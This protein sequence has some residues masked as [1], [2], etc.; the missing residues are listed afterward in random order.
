MGRCWDFRKLIRASGSGEVADL[1]LLL[2]NR[3]RVEITSSIKIYY[4]WVSGSREAKQR[5]AK[6]TWISDA[7]KIKY[8][9]ADVSVSF[10][11]L[12]EMRM[13]V[14]TAT[15]LPPQM[16]KWNVHRAEQNKQILR[17]LWLEWVNPYETTDIY[18]N[19]FY[20]SIALDI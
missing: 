4:A 1:V 3:P 5:Q 8:E 6:V 18:W 15:A 14:S 19:A 7:Y 20:L 12:K 11:V 17:F 10:N 2:Q 16:A 13:M 9:L